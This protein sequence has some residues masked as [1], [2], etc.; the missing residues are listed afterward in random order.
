M[1]GG[2]KDMNNRVAFV[3]E[4]LAQVLTER[5]AGF[6][7]PAS[8]IIALWAKGEFKNF[9]PTMGLLDMEEKRC[10]INDVAKLSPLTIAQATA[11]VADRIRDPATNLGS[12][13]RAIAEIQAERK[14]AGPRVRW[15]SLA[16][17]DSPWGV[18]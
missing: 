3:V 14:G 12:A 16:L 11:V 4:A 2:P 9:S 6:E 10:I 8:E 1:R 18:H 5:G 15:L 17:F 7:Q 13:I